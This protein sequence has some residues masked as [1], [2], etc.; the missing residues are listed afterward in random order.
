[1]T[2]VNRIS[3]RA[4]PLGRDNIDTDVIIAADHL[5]TTTRSGLGKYAFAPIRAEP[6][7]VFDDPE[8][9]NAPILIAGANFGCGS[10]REHAAWAMDDMG[11]RAVIAPG[12]SDIFSSNAYKNGL[13]T[14]VLPA[15]DVA[16]LMHLAE[17]APV[18]I[19]LADMT[20]TAGNEQFAF[21]LD[22]FRRASLMSGLDE[23]GLTLKSEAAIKA[24]E[25]RVGV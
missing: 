22:P 3:G 4:Y 15:A 2:P 20:V 9:A 1:M 12:F 23:I 19:D 6:G 8:F 18:T 24:Y 16:S 11:I 25:E 21:T 5:K 7:N 10:S 14:V 17:H 13:V